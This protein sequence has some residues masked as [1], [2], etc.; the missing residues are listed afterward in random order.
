MQNYRKSEK[1]PSWLVWFGLTNLSPCLVVHNTSPS[2]LDTRCLYS[3]HGEQISFEYMYFSE[4][5]YIIIAMWCGGD[6]HRD[7]VAADDV[8][9]IQFLDES[10]GSGSLRIT[11]NEIS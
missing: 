5:L 3:V 7:E 10:F 1:P 8:T 2:P 9:H 6:S 11:A 4:C